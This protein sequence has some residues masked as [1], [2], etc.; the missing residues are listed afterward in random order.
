MRIPSF[1]SIILIVLLFNTN[2]I[3]NEKIV[4]VFDLIK[5]K[6]WQKSFQ[7]AH[8]L[9]DPVLEKIVLSQ[10]FLDYKYKDN[11]FEKI[12][13]FLKQNPYWPQKKQIQINA[14]N[15]LNENTPIN[16]ILSWFNSNPPLTDKGRKYYAL[17]CAKLKKLPDNFAKIVK[18]AWQKGNFSKEEQKIYYDRFKQY[19]TKNDHIK[20]IDYYLSKEKITAARELYYLVDKEQRKSF[21]AQIALINKDKNAIAKFK[22]IH[23]QHYTAGL[24]FRYLEARKKDDLSS[25]NIARLI[26][27]AGDDP[28]Y[29]D[30]IWHVVHYIAREYIEKK[31]F[32]DAYKIT[33][34]NL[35]Q[36]PSSK[37]NAEF[38]SGWLALQF[39]KKPQLALQYFENFN[40][41]VKTPISKS[42]GIYWL[43]RTHE[44]LKNKEKAN[45][46]YRLAATKYPYTFYG[47]IAANEIGVEKIILAGNPSG[48]G[49]DINKKIS[50]FNNNQ[51]AKACELVI[52]YGSKVLSE[53]YIENFVDNTKNSQDII[54]LAA[55]INNTTHLHSKTWLAKFALQKHVVL[56]DAAYPTPYKVSKLPIEMPLIYSIIR[57]ETVFDQSAVSTANAKGLMQLLDST[58][59]LVAKKI[60]VECT[61]TKLTK[62]PAYNI[63]LG[64][65]Y[66]H[67]MIER[68]DGSYILAIL[69]YN[70]GP[71][72]VDKWLKTYG[73]PRNMKHHRQVLDW[74]ELVPYYETRN[75]I[76]RVLENLQIYRSILHPEIK[77]HII[78]D[79]KLGNNFGV[80]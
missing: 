32:N 46:L 60:G 77:L 44:I 74:L 12:T 75:Y 3:A 13:N 34:T 49:I 24:I 69:S 10:Q 43:A 21:D 30:K 72:K 56:R 25:A 39:L 36:V 64:S 29:A 55:K 59:C 4:A 54:N 27:I 6:E 26:T 61:P 70:C 58:A 51:L 80:K 2:A 67:Q 9:N 31:N 45:K 5:Q 35:S 1:L 33:S 42:R 66:L 52:K 57:Q 28:E 71:H 16:S 17:A 7:S 79:L 50:D 62:D 37:S 18:S 76:Q 73:D 38:L 20:K 63:L 47:Q 78:Q 65:N 40:Q 53:I 19:L 15:L 22:S 11:S 23:K 68:F 14:E 41:I 48:A 8:E